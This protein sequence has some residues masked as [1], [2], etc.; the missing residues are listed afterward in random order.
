LRTSTRPCHPTHPRTVLTSS[1]NVSSATG[2]RYRFFSL[3]HTKLLTLNAQ[4]RP[5]AEQLQEHAWVRARDTPI[6]LAKLVLQATMP[7]A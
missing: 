2:A 6:A 1:S 4:Q 5:S 3:Y 7:V